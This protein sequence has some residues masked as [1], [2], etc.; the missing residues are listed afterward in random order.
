MTDEN[1]TTEKQIPQAA[2][3]NQPSRNDRHKKAET[4]ANFWARIKAKWPNK[5]PKENPKKQ[6]VPAGELKWVRIRMFPIWLRLLILLALMVLAALLGAII[7]FSVVG[8]GS[9]GDVFQK[10][11]WQHIF[12]I[13]NGK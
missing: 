8:D 3:A 13:M 1:R 6:E 10:D 5:S 11:T 12:D 7:G 9:A 4:D 2:E